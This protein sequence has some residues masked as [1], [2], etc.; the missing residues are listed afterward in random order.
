MTNYVLADRDQN[1]VLFEDPSKAS[2]QFRIKRN[3]G[4][5]TV[6]ALKLHNIRAEYV[7]TREKTPEGVDDANIREP[8]SVRL[9]TTGSDMNQAEIDKMID[10]LFAAVIQLR[11]ERAAGRLPGPDTVL[12]IDPTNT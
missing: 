11:V 4:R 9:I 1:V 8:L 6:D 10:T 5:K 3:L 12:A 7:V 2:S